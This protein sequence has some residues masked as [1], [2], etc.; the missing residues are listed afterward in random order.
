MIL[1]V[2][3]FTAA[4]SDYDN[5]IRVVEDYYG[6]AINGIRGTRFHGVQLAFR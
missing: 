4:E 6:D 3:F 1:T 2:F 5:G